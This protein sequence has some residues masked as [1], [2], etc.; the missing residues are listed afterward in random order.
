[1]GARRKA[2]RDNGSSVVDEGRRVCLLPIYLHL[3]TAGQWE[4]SAVTPLPVL[5][6]VSL[7]CDVFSRFV[8]T[9][10]LCCRQMCL[11][12][13]SSFLFVHLAFVFFRQGH[14]T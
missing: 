5:L 13:R 12:L 10:G 11:V 7:L 1:M 6:L 8:L 2:E 3:R 4:K 9:K 14:S